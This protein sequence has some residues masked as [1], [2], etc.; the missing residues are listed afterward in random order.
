MINRIERSSSC[1]ISVAFQ[2]SRLES[3]QSIWDDDPTDSDYML[4]DDLQKL[5]DKYVM[6]VNSSVTPT[7]LWRPFIEAV[8]KDIDTLKLSGKDKVLVADLEYLKDV[9][10]LLA[11]S[12][13]D[14]IGDFGSVRDG[15]LQFFG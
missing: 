8:F 14:E 4:V 6:E 9:A 5:T 11:V 3:N 2:L 13:E 15:R 7:P 10:L 12:E 1:L